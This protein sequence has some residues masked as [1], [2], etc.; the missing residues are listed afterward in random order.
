LTT[1][2][3]TSET[4][5]TEGKRRVFRP[6]G[7]TIGLIGIIPLFGLEP[8]I[9]LY[10]AIR[11]NT[12]ADGIISGGLPLDHWR[13]AA[14]IA[15]VVVIITSL[16]A[17]VGKPRAVQFLV[18]AAVV[19]SFALSLVSVWVRI[20]GDCAGCLFDGATQLLDDIFR[21]KIPIQIL[22]LLYFL[23]YINRAPS[24]AFFTQTPLP[25]WNDDE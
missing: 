15:G 21:C 14:G 17:W 3:P 2:T 16:M 25:P 8:L 9:W 4:P 11:L 7:L 23:W 22:A 19:T 6:L 1:A 18:Q 20:Y 13:W 12:D 5:A 24:R 10:V